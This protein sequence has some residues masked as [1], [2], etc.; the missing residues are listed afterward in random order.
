ML[1]SVINQ[2][3]WVLAPSSVVSETVFRPAPAVEEEREED[4]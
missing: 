2:P 1:E 3:D 4:N